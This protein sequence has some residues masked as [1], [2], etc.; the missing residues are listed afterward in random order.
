[1]A[2][3]ALN[4]ATKKASKLL[5]R[6][7]DLHQRQLEIDDAAKEA[8]APLDAELAD[9]KAK[10]EGWAN[11]NPAAFGG[12]KTMTLEGGTFGF[13]LG[14]K[15]VSFPLDGP[16]EIKDA[17]LKIVKT[18]MSAAI[19]ESVDSKKVAATW[20]DYPR[21][22]RRLGTL[23]ITVKQEDSFFITPKK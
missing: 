8:K 1:M 10:L 9:V 21:L 6:Y 22:V 4:P 11:T 18:E 17:Y 7:A 5:E 13:K 23:G 2:T 15:A 3:V 14:T 16:A 20:G 19:L 12:K